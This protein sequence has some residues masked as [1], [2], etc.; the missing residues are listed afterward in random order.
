MTAAIWG[1]T[2]RRG[3]LRGRWKCLQSWF[4]GGRTFKIIGRRDN[5]RFE[6][7]G[8]KFNKNKAFGSAAAFL[9]A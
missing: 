8:K 2:R 1:P 7:G 3:S 5:S 6:V 4:T 9:S